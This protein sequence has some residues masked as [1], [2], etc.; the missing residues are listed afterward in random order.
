MRRFAQ[1]SRFRFEHEGA[2]GWTIQRKVIANHHANSCLQ[3]VCQ[4]ETDYTA[5]HVVQGL[6]PPVGG[7]AEVLL[8]PSAGKNLSDPS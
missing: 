5:I 3:E 1:S 2:R 8:V 4:T 6:Y 7:R